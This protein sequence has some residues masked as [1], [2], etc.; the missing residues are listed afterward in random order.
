MYWFSYRWSCYKTSSIGYIAPVTLLVTL[1]N[2]YI[3]IYVCVCVCVYVLWRGI[4]SR[5]GRGG[6]FP[7]PTVFESTGP[8]DWPNP[9]QNE[10]QSYLHSMTCNL[11]D[12][13]KNPGHSYNMTGGNSERRKIE[14]KWLARPFSAKI[15]PFRL[16]KFGKESSVLRTEVGGE[17]RQFTAKSSGRPP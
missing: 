1:H 7:Y 9:G 5:E 14:A 11:L 17:R 6:K 13:E 10:G 15:I 4:L 16:R 2:I 8:K 3:Y 12:E